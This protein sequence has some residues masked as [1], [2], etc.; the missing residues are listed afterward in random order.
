MFT[1]RGNIPDSIT[2]VVLLSVGAS[3]NLTDRQEHR[4]LRDR[5]SNSQDNITCFTFYRT[6]KLQSDFPKS[7]YPRE[8]NLLF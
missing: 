2:V 6:P 8:V 5:I 1:V 4:N 7:F 3:K